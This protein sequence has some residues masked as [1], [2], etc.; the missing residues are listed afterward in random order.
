MSLLN[1]LRDKVLLA[2]Q[3]GRKPVAVVMSRDVREEIGREIEGLA[4]HAIADPKS[5]PDTF[6]AL[7]VEIADGR[8]HMSVRVE[9]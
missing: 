5:A 7:P 6:M 8:D 3:S 4:A 2:H 9:S 1:E